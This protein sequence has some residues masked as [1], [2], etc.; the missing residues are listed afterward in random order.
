MSNLILFMGK[1]KRG[2]YIF[3]SWAGDHPPRHVHIMKDG[4]FVAKWNLEANKVM[5]GKVSRQII[6]ILKELVK[7][8]RL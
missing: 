5:Q 6:Q 1:I 4:K 3:Y 2:G 7:E 8:G